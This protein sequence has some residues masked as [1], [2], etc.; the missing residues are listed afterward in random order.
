[1]GPGAEVSIDDLHRADN[2][3]NNDVKLG[4]VIT[5]ANYG[6]ARINNGDD[7][8]TVVGKYSTNRILFLART[9]AGRMR[10]PGAMTTAGSRCGLS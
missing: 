10:L 5:Y 2:F 7:S 8:G 4:D 3:K 1:M 9:S 6:D